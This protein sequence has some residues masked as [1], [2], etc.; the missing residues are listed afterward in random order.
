MKHQGKHSLIQDTSWFIMVTDLNFNLHYI[1]WLLPQEPCHIFHDS[2]DN[3]DIGFKHCTKGTSKYMVY[4]YRADISRCLIQHWISLPHMYSIYNADTMYN[5]SKHSIFFLF[6]NNTYFENGNTENCAYLLLICIRVTHNTP[7][8]IHTPV[9]LFNKK[10]LQV[11]HIHL[12]Y[13]ETI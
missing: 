5:N 13:F 11:H 1:Y 7:V 2:P 4:G 12:S 6:I 9:I 10:S 8:F 3:L